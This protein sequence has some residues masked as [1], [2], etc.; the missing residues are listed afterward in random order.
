VQ[1]LPLRKLR[2]TNVG[3]LMREESARK[4]EL[5]RAVE[6]E[7]REAALLTRE[8]RAQADTKARA[9]ASTLKG[10][11][12]ERRFIAARA[13]FAASRLVTRHAGLADL[14]NR[15]RW[16][17]WVGVGV[18]LVAL[19]AGFLANE[20]GTDK[21]LDL[22]AVPL[23]GTIAW[24]LFVYLWIVITTI[25]RRGRRN[26]LTA[27]LAKLAGFGRQGAEG[28]TAIERT[29]ASFSSRWAELTAPLTAA[30]TSRTF[31]LGA[32]LFAAGLIG[33]I[34][35]RA[36]VI[37]YR[38]GWEST[39]LGP[40]AVHSVLSTVLGPASHLTGVAIPPLS[41]IA[42]MRWTG[43]GTGGVNAAPWIHL[44]TATV[45]GLVVLPRLALAGWQALRGLRLARNLPVAGRED[46][47]IRRLLRAS[48]AA[49]GRAR[50]TP[51]A[52]NPREETR[53]RIT[54]TLR[55]VLGDEAE[56]RF[57]EPVA[58]GAED[59]WAAQHSLDPGDDYHLLLFSLSST[60]EAENHGIFAKRLADQGSSRGKGTVIGALI[61]ES[62]YREHFAGQA[63][64]DERIETRLDAWR[65][66]LAPAGVAPTGIDLSATD[67]DALAKRIE[68]NL[69]R[70][71]DLSR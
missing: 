45:L 43:L 38:A 40:Q 70:D 10:R 39:F 25:L 68:G 6:V 36:L 23:V 64:L 67:D 44:Y 16:P 59:N 46:F 18:P 31:H 48:G 71:A 62:P 60:P 27:A 58:Y 52:Y 13:D 17:G 69:I 65:A 4:V 29:A 21:H 9:A 22:L 24:N 49:P 51:Y 1:R 34:Y 26:P 41:D 61:D 14:L 66:I 20:F 33:G 15:S 12:F 32:A 7:D 3:G 37:E 30:R 8:D 11:E 57:D 42:A 2:E 19:A 28:G 47:Y 63:G 53:R 54:A 35:L 55:A 56:V 50:V 5:V